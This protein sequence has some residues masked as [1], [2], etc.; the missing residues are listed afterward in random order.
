MRLNRLI[1]NLGPARSVL[2]GGVEYRVE[3][4]TG[5][6]CRIRFVSPGTGV[7]RIIAPEPRPGWSAGSMETFWVYASE[8]QI[9]KAEDTSLLHDQSLRQLLESCFLALEAEARVFADE[10]ARRE[11]ASGEAVLSRR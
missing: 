11:D 1:L 7:I 10:N 3:T 2:S 4:L 9:A 5:G 6:A 8:K